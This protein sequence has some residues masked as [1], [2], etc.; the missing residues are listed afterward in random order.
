MAIYSR[1]PLQWMISC[2]FM[3]LV[4]LL[5]FMKGFLLTRVELPDASPK[6]QADSFRALK[7]Y[8][9]LVL[10]IVDAV[11]YDF[12]CE[13]S[14]AGKPFA[15][16]FPKTVGKVEAAV[17]WRLKGLLWLGTVSKLPWRG[18]LGGCIRTVDNSLLHGFAVQHL[19]TSCF[20]CSG[21]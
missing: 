12:V 9:K 21:A 20:S 5:I 7:R 18:H 6:Q 16:A 14:T 1:S 2:S 4:V 10:L 11:R 3:H 15:G 8:N 17:G 13:P 19:R